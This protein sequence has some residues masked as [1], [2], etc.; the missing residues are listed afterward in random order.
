VRRRELIAMAAAGTVWPTLLR[1]QPPPVP[2]IGMLTATSPEPF[3]SEVLAALRELGYIA[4][5]S[6]VVEFRSTAEGTARLAELAAELVRLKVDVI[7]A[8]QTPAAQA[9]KQATAEIP[10][11]MLAGDPVATGLVASLA[12]PGGNVTGLSATTAEIAAKNV[13]L[14]REVQPSLRRIGVLANATDPFTRPFLEQI[15]QG[16]RMIGI[17]IKPIMIRRADELD[18]AFAELRRAG[19]GAVIIQPSVP[20]RAAAELALRHLLPAASP[21]V[22]FPTEGGLIAYASRATES[23]R[24]M[25]HYVVQ[26]LKGRKPADLPVEQ[27]T[28]F[29]LAVNLKTAKALGITIPPTILARA[30]EVIE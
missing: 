10:I 18:G 28:S 24:R 2:R 27:P 5:Q 15:E 3:R 11:V 30:D 29:D 21:T 17:E 26:I 14:L 7:V 4:G 23:F 19:V 8:H 6:I 13:E 16:A 1:A 20:R 9:A 25:A 12:R 22:L